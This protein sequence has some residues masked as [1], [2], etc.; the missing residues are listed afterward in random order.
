MTQRVLLRAHSSVFSVLPIFGKCSEA[1]ADRRDGAR[2]GRVGLNTIGRMTALAEATMVVAM[3]IRARDNKSGS[4]IALKWRV[5]V[6]WAQ[7]AAAGVRDTCVLCNATD[8][9]TCV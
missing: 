6:A 1:V 8:M 5:C 3:M 2:R 7:P 9:C 4:I